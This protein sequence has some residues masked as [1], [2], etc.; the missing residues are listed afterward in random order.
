MLRATYITEISKILQS[1]FP[2]FAVCVAVIPACLNPQL[3]NN[4]TTYPSFL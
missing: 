4:Y 1:L 2:L 3:I